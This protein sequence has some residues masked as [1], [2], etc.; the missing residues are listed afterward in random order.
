M[1]LLHCSHCWISSCSVRGQSIQVLAHF[2]GRELLDGQESTSCIF[3]FCGGGGGG[4]AAVCGGGPGGGG[5][6]SMASICDGGP[7]GSSPAELAASVCDG[8][9]ELMLEL[10]SSTM[11]EVPHCCWHVSFN[12]LPSESSTSLLSR[13]GENVFIQESEKPGQLG[14]FGSLRGLGESGSMS[15]IARLSCES[16]K[17]VCEAA[18]ISA[19]SRQ[20]LIQ[21]VLMAS[22]RRSCSMLSRRLF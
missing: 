12:H 13:V 17:H 21:V 5:G 6:G 22:A 11:N 18:V 1:H 10:E 20:L 15:A 2:N 7:A 14:A 4:A 19:S 16:V 9:P 3:L 8:G